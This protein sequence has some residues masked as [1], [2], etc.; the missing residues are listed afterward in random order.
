MN[1]MKQNLGQANLSYGYMAHH[2]EGLNWHM[3]FMSH[4]TTYFYIAQRQAY[5]YK[6]M[7]I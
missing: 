5:G 4:L 7:N 1:G 3:I 2:N 6:N